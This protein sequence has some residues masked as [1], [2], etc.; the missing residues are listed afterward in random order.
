MSKILDGERDP[1]RADET[2]HGTAMYLF[3][4]HLFICP[5]TH[6]GGEKLRALTADH[7]C[8]ARRVRASFMQPDAPPSAYIVQYTQL[9]L[10]I[11]IIN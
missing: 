7:A 2:L 3:M 1:H 8:I 10:L 9:E 4:C 11:I 6:R 5:L